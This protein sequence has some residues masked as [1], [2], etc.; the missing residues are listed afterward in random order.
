MNIKPGFVIIGGGHAAGRAIEAMREAGYTGLITLIGAEHELPYERPALSKELL[1]NEKSNE[2]T[3]INDSNWYAE[4]NVELVLGTTADGLDQNNKMITCTDGRTFTYEKLLITTGARVRRLNIPGTEHPSIH[5]LRT[6]N[7]AKLLS[8]QLTKGKKLVVIGGGFIG[9]EVAASAS[10]RGV[11]VSIVE[12]GERLMGRAVPPLISQ[13]I[14]SR[15]QSEGAHLYFNSTPLKI[16]RDENGFSLVVLD[17]GSII[18]ADLVVIGIG[19]EPETSLAINS[20]LAVDNGILTDSFCN[21]SDSAIYAAGDCTNHFNSLLDKRIRLESWQNAQ[22]QAIVAAHNMCGKKE[23]HSE[24]PWFWSDQ[25]DIN[26]QIA[27]LPGVWNTPI[28]RGEIESGSFILFNLED[29]II[30]AVAGVNAGRDM[31]FARR[32]IYSKNRLTETM[33]TDLSLSLRQLAKEK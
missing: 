29:G 30:T 27:G 5:Y 20:G 31:S 4:K 33:L 28:L 21:T 23:I 24:I 22:N 16:D 3:F 19:V 2:V 25:Y 13:Y 10:L 6:L 17:D 14:A 7:D 15:H 8:S 9:L 11:T 26:L 32:L 18:E 12:S 1:I